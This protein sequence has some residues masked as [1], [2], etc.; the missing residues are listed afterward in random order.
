MRHHKLLLLFVVLL[1]TG[2]CVAE[3]VLVKGYVT[4][5]AP[6]S[7]RGRTRI[8]LYANGTFLDALLATT[9]TDSSGD[10]KGP[11]FYRVVIE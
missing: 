5:D 11:Y 9:Y 1:A 6:P 4:L 7:T 2:G 8:D 3:T 10:G